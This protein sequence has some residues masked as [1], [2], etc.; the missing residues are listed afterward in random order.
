MMGRLDEAELRLTEAA[1]LCQ[2]TGDR[3]LAAETEISL[4]AVLKQKGDFAGAAAALGVAIRSGRE[5]GNR[6][7]VASA[8]NNLGTLEMA[9]G[10]IADAQR[11]MTEAVK[12]AREVKSGD[13]LATSL[14]NLARIAELK[15]DFTSALSS[16]NESCAIREKIGQTGPLASCRIFH[17]L[18]LAES[19]NKTAAKAELDSAM[20]VPL[21]RG[22]LLAL[23]WARVAELRIE[24]GDLAGAEEAVDKGR[25]DRKKRDYIPEQDL[26]VELAGAK[27]ESAR[28]N[29]QTAVSL[30]EQVRSKAERAGLKVIS[31]EAGLASAQTQGAVS[32]TRSAAGR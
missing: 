17:S 6:D 27:I 15:G 20:A 24:R 1:R 21:T 16:L 14:G 13:N 26:P 18:L 25:L 7:T 32:R 12:L 29:R 23:D 10:E 19:G 8:V 28:G 22:G 30:M 31:L 2:K 9:E 4:G 3:I 11:N 5:I